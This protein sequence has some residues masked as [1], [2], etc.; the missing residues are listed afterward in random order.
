MAAQRGSREEPEWLKQSDCL[1]RDGYM[2]AGD[3]GRSIEPQQAGWH[4]WR[5]FTQIG[6]RL[7]DSAADLVFDEPNDL[8]VD[9]PSMVTLS[10]QDP[11]IRF[12]KV[13]EFERKDSVHHTMYFTRPETARFVIDSFGLKR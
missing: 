1:I 7:K 3:N 6:D 13:L 9:K 12:K 2:M 5:Y 4:F 10:S 8:D 11:Q